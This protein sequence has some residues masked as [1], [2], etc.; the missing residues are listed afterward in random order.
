MKEFKSQKIKTVLKSLLKKKDITYEDLADQMECSVPTIKRIL[1]QEELTLNRLLQLCEIVEIDLADLET[2]I[3]EEKRSD[4]KFTDDQEKFL[5]KNTNFFAYLMTLFEGKTPKQIAEENNLTQKST[6]KYLIGLEK[7]DLIKVTGKQKVKPAF[8]SLPT[9]GNGPLGRIYAEAFVQ[10]GAKFFSNT[11]HESQNKLTSE[12]KVNAKF[13]LQGM[14]VEK[15]TYDAW[16]EE[17]Q[18][19]LLAFEKL[20]QFE[21]KTKPEES[22]MTVVVMRAHTIVKNDYPGL[23]TLKNALGNITNF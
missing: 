11:I 14:K 12:E 16:I 23:N 13:S 8:K 21:E 2:L 20:C 19:S 10:S 9:L 18:K 15:A 7:L 4:E 1:G 3:H 5:A 22:L 6:D 17:Q